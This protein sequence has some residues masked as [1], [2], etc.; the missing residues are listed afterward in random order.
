MGQL[1]L[2]LAFIYV[3]TSMYK[4]GIIY[5]HGRCFVLE[6]PVPN[7]ALGNLTRFK[8]VSDLQYHYF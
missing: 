4:Y 5:T 2:Y 1:D 3:C 8:S 7:I 6:F